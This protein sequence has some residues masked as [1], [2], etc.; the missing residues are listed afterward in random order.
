MWLN[1]KRRRG[2][3][4][5][6]AYLLRLILCKLQIHLYLFRIAHFKDLLLIGQSMIP[7]TQLT[8]NFWC[9]NPGVVR[10]KSF[11]HKYEQQF[12]KKNILNFE[13]VKVFHLS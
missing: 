11:F 2:G 12:F 8:L 4:F 13:I 3:K 1:S 9:M 7:T 6:Q 10:L 5:N